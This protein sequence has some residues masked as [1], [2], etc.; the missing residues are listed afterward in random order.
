MTG[1]LFGCEV[2]I[3]IDTGATESFVDPSVVAKLPIRAGYMENPWLVEYG[4][5]IERRVEQCLSCSELELPTFHTQVNLY[6]AQL[7]SYDVILGI[8]WLTE[9]KAIV[10]C[11]DK[12]VECLDDFGNLVIVNEI[13]RPIV[14]RHI[15]AMQLKKAKRKG[16]QLFVAHI[17]DLED[18]IPSIED[19]PIL[20]EFRDVFPEELPELPP[21][22]E[23]DFSIDIKPGAEPQSKAPYRMTNTEMYELKVQLQELLDKGFIRPSVSPWGAPVIFVKKKDGTLRLCIDYRMLNKV[24][25]KNRYPLPRIDEF[26]IR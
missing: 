3:L 18:P 8:N 15:S 13:K 2:S 22:R 25:I 24:T 16:C 12:L 11:K 23:F 20:Q 26:L 21:K 14:L 10:N 9:H 17:K 4:N 6:V 7:G 19:Y 1:K 5:R